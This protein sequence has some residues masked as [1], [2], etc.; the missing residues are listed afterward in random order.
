M[1]HILE[2]FPFQQQN[3]TSNEIKMLG[4]EGAGLLAGEGRLSSSKIQW[5]GEEDMEDFVL[6]WVDFQPWQ[7]PRPFKCKIVKYRKTGQ[8]ALFTT[9]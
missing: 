7:T 8:I 5:W 6:K 3:V 2:V 9:L 4:T 1:S